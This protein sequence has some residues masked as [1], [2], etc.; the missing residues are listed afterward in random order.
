MMQFILSARKLYRNN[1]YH[2]FEHAFN[3]CHC[4]HAILRRNLKKF[5]VIEVCINDC[6]SFT[7]KNFVVES[8]N[9]SSTLS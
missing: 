9:N 5:S 1:P 2:N 4:M 3:V 8:T 7:K 6:G